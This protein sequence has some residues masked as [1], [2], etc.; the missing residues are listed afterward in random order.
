VS[1]KP[2]TPS[3]EP[4]EIAI[5]VRNTLVE[6]AEMKTI[7]KKAQELSDRI[8]KITPPPLFV[9]ETPREKQR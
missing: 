4:E 5:V 7:E 3:K 2:E 9:E 6:L 8:A 1:S